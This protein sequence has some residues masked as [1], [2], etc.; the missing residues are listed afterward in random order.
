M[1]V[2]DLKMIVTGGA[3]GMGRFFAE[4]LARRGAQ[5]AVGD[6]DAAGL[7]TLPEGIH[8]KALNVADDAAVVEFTAWA[9]EQM[10]GLN[11]LI[12]NAG[13]IRDGLLVRK[14]RRTGEVKAQAVAEL[15]AVFNVNLRGATLMVR[16]VVTHMVQSESPGVIVNMSSISRNGN[17]GQTA[18]VAAKASLAANTVTWAREFARYGIRVGAIAPGLI[19]TPMTAGMN[20]AALDKIK[21]AIPL[22][23]MGKPVDIWQAVQFIVECDYFTGA[24][25]DVNGGYGF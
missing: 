4:E 24:T 1:N 14:D 21:S 12:N 7:A 22:R 10:G 3:G 9:A 11:G 6:V 18:Y 25:I 17:R 13:I 16:E 19:E 5:V 15:D 20:Q 2:Q 8:R 23:R